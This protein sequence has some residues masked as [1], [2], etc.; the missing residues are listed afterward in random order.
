MDRI[1]SEDSTWYFMQP[2]PE[3]TKPH[4]THDI[5]LECITR[6]L[7]SHRLVSCGQR[8]Q[9]NGDVMS[10][11]S[12]WYNCYIVLYNAPVSKFWSLRAPFLFGELQYFLPD[13]Y[14]PFISHTHWSFHYWI[15]IFIYTHL[16]KGTKLS[17]VS[18]LSLEYL[19]TVWNS[20]WPGEQTRC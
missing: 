8:M 4:F 9:D 17:Q 3:H 14:M 2:A 11:E 6:I 10:L 15:I 19:L 1:F 13:K 20:V 16:T 12:Y 5:T 7:H 18:S